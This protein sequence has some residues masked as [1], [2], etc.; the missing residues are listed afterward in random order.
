MRLFRYLILISCLC[1]MPT[2]AESAS[3]TGVAVDAVNNI[4][5]PLTKE[6]AAELA[7][8]E[9]GGRI[10]SV[11]EEK[12]EEIDLFRVKVLHENGTVRTY[13]IERDTGKR[14]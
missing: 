6:T 7:K 10:L 5:L 9:T 13:R 8:V 3:E 14:R 12:L 2:M 4:A 1:S 11:H